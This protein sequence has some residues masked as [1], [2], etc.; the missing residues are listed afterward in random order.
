MLLACLFILIV[1]FIFITRH[2]YIS[3]CVYIYICACV[4]VSVLMYV[5]FYIHI[6]VLT[7]YIFLYLLTRLGISGVPLQFSSYSL[8]AQTRYPV[9]RLEHD[10]CFNGE[11]LHLLGFDAIGGQPQVA[12]PR[13][14]KLYFGMGYAQK[15]LRSLTQP[16]AD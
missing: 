10:I 3:M 1:S 4:C 16:Y 8:I 7:A 13:H 14:C 15:L 2:I 6:Y 11:H 12:L 5:S 9:G